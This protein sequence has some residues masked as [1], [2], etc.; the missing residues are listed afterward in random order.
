MKKQSLR[1]VLASVVVMS[2]LAGSAAYAEPTAGSLSVD[3][4]ISERIA[5]EA[6]DALS[7][8]LTLVGEKSCASV[9]SSRARVSYSVEV[10]RDGGDP[11][12]PVLRFHVVRNENSQQQ[13]T[14][15]KFKLTSELRRGQR[16][17]VL[18]RLRYSDGD[19]TSLTAAVR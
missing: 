7:T 9:E 15:K 11:A 17:V 14:S 10:C 1:M 4:E 3:I 12:T 18:G 8:T 6:P 19:E 13:N 16:A 5:K 2:G